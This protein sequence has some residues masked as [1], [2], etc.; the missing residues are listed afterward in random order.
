MRVGST[1]MGRVIQD[2]MNY[3]GYF[4][5]DKNVDFKKDLLNKEEIL[6]CNNL[7]NNSGNL[8]IKSHLITPD[9]G[10]SLLKINQ[11][12]KI[13]N[14]LRD[15]KDAI[16]SRYHYAVNHLKESDALNALDGRERGFTAEE[17]INFLKER[18]DIIKK[19]KQDFENFN[20]E[21]NSSKFLTLNYEKLNSGDESEFLRLTSFLGKDVDI[22]EIIKKHS[23]QNYKNQESEKFDRSSD[24][25]FFVRKGL[26]G[27]G[28]KLNI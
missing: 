18:T 13:I 15:E 23:F 1:W 27:E 7:I 9:L 12:L 21:I 6:Y 26:N 22:K 2:I 25:A 11:N 17:G 3:D 14:V 5:L 19:W 20:I 4:Y 16:L 8:Y 24:D 10:L 28:S